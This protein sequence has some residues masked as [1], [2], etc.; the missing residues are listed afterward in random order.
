[1]YLMK[2]EESCAENKQSV[3]PSGSTISEGSNGFSR[4]SAAGSSPASS[5]P[6]HRRMTGPIRRA[7]GGWTPEEDETLKHAVELHKG[8]SWKTIAKS[9]PGRT[10]V[11]CL[12]RWQKVLNPALVKGSWAPEEDGTI[13]E[14]V[15]QYGP[16]KWSV[17]ARSLP[18]RIGKQCRERWHNHL[19]PDIRKDAWSPE[20]E[21]K[22]MEAHLKHGNKWAE[23]AKMLPGRTDNSIK[24]HWN[25][26]LRKKTELFLKT[27]KLPPA[28]MPGIQYGA[29]DKAN[30][31][32]NQN[33]NCSNKR[34]VTSA[35]ILPEN[36]S[37]AHSS[38][39]PKISEAES[40]ESLM[41]PVSVQVSEL[42]SLDE[43]AKKSG[44]QIWVVPVF[45]PVANLNDS[46]VIEGKP[47]TSDVP[48]CPAQASEIDS[49]HNSSDSGVSCFT[50][51]VCQNEKPS[52]AK[53]YPVADNLSS[54]CYKPP[55][56]EDIGVSVLSSL[57]FE[58]NALQPAF[59]VETVSSPDGHS[60]PSSMN[61]TRSFQPSIESILRSAARS[62]Q[63][64]PSIIKRRSEAHSPVP[65][66]TMS[67][68]ETRV[69]DSCTPNEER[70]N[71]VEGSA[72]SIS[73]LSFSPCTINEDLLDKGKDFDISPPYRLWSKRKATFKPVE[74]Q[75]DFSL[76]KA[77]MDVNTKISSFEVNKNSYIPTNMH[78]WA[79]Q[80]K[81]LENNLADLKK[82]TSPIR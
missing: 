51:E 17:I 21:M 73:K 72:F 2:A 50:P 68:N 9:V 58:N 40:Q 53:L 67:T 27:G 6:S 44:R 13:I 4:M 70:F 34:L 43:A 36:C 38:V 3:T 62:F 64:T 74:K 57:L 47:D 48:Q 18:G 61:V 78:V 46:L 24:N 45:A 8:R 16:T 54:L 12:H 32:P 26:S 39:P 59:K 63:N 20:E 1:M 79:M 22:L 25:S 81:K 19:S 5:S 31:G 71:N 55:Q 42:N 65:P 23:I 77:N 37:S 75:L 49:V 52:G 60:T 41:V 76:E 35:K 80:G 69:Q 30:S 15:A 29:E 10:D 33:F 28:H 82:V 7:K 14:L 11:Q 56:L 66:V